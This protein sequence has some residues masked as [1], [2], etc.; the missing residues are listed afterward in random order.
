MFKRIKLSLFILLSCLTI[1]LLGAEEKMSPTL[2]DAAFLVF[3]EDPTRVLPKAFRTSNSPYHQ[4]KLL[5]PTRAGL[6]ALHIAGSG[7]FS[8]RSL[9][10]A[11]KS[12]SG[13]IWIV[14]LRRESHG[15]INGLPISWYYSENLSNV[16]LSSKEILLKEHKMLEGLK[17]IDPVPVREI[18][19]KSQG[20]IIRT[21]I[22][23]VPVSILETE[24][25][26]TS[27][28]NLHYF[29][30]PVSDHHHPDPEMV[31]H[32]I[33]FVNTAPKDAWLYFHCRGGKGRTTTFMVLFDMLKNAKNI[34]LQEIVTRQYLLGGS[35]LFNFSDDEDEIWK[36]DKQIARKAFIEEF[37]KY[38]SSTEGYPKIS[39]T[40]WLKR[41][42]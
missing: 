36:R 7:Q 5:A 25:Q 18:Q 15:F 11:I 10:D 24:S 17:E 21:T 3:D 2:S 12:M 19:R 29:R 33:D 8:E 30:L 20:N 41:R 38:A 9:L 16:D 14:D 37:Y 22:I 6:E 26:L 35:D 39:W 4:Q 34:P 32:F 13:E 23:E 1:Q 27:K 40:A 28:H 42:T 31:D